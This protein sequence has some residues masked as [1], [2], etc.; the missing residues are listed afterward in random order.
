MREI[1]GKILTI[2]IFV[3]A[4]I[5]MVV[6]S[7]LIHVNIDLAMLVFCI[8]FLIEFI[9]IMALLVIEKVI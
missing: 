2:L 7:M 1:L 4:M 9:S 8:G 6:S 3:G 5:G